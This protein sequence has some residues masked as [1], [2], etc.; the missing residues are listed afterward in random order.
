MRENHNIKAD[1]KCMW[2]HITTNSKKPFKSSIH[3]IL[4]RDDN[5]TFSI[6]FPTI[7]TIL[8][9]KSTIK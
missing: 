2:L 1:G 5:V 7:P 8:S 9:Y 4:P 3:F 6:L